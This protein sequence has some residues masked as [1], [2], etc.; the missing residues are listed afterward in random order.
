MTWLPMEAADMRLMRL[1]DIFFHNIGG[2]K[3]WFHAVG[4][5]MLVVAAALPAQ[6]RPASEESPLIEWWDGGQA[7]DWMGSRKGMGIRS[8]IEDHGFLFNVR[9][10]GIYFGILEAE[11]GQ[12]DAFTQEWAG[13]AR[14]DFAK[15]TGASVL[16]GLMAFG[17]V[18]WRE[19]GAQSFP[20]E[21]VE[22]SNLFNPSR[23]AGG[24][25]WRLM[26]F[27]LTYAVSGTSG[28]KDFLVLT[29]GWL[30]PQREF[31]DQ[32]R[33]RLFVNNAVVSSG[34]I[35]GNIPFSSS[36]STWGA[37]IRV[38]P[39]DW[40]YTKV[41]LFMSYPDATASGNNGL[42][43]RGVP[44][45]NDFFAIGE[46]GVTPKIGSGKLP[47]C[48]AFGGYY[49][50]DGTGTHDG[51]QYGAYLQAD[52]MIFREPSSGDGPPGRQGLH[53]FSV[54]ST[55]PADN[56][57]YPF[58]CHGGL[59]Y[60]GL[61]PSRD[62]DQTMFSVACG[63]YSSVMQPGRDATTFLEAGYRVQIN[64]W[65]FVQPFAQYVARPNGTSR[66]G[67]AALLELFMGMDF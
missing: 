62:K 36:F 10:R 23:Y 60:E 22:A 24:V 16:D 51:T 64:G 42:M 55:A 7:V 2:Q 67:D 15:L 59:V 53:L 39:R 56:D 30:Q 61:I 65:S 49:Y 19:P 25:G 38:K 26:N 27:G 35:G 44:S 6:A 14:L 54:F 5:V 17:E 1:A 32:P 9:W 45:R 50:G 11:G 48:Y 37:T 58:Y 13:A 20:N 66:V 18:R 52:Q 46:T 3:A 8:K 28:I 47:G 12:G 31:I 33:S 41:G 57:R 40:Q 4:I 34:G 21:R 43:F 29:G 63:K